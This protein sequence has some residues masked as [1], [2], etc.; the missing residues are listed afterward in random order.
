MPLEICPTWVMPSPLSTTNPRVPE[1]WAKLWQ[2]EPW[3]QG[4]VKTM[5]TISNPPKMSKS[6]KPGTIWNM[7][8]IYCWTACWN[9]FSIFLG[10]ATMWQISKLSIYHV[11]FDNIGTTLMEAHIGNIYLIC[12]NDMIIQKYFFL[13]SAC[14]S[15]YTQNLQTYPSVIKHGHGHHPCTE[16]VQSLNLVRGFPSHDWFPSH[17]CN[18][19]P[20]SDR[21][22]FD[23]CFNP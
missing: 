9:T 5:S 13:F 7:K 21:I 16:Y 14:Q 8:Y 23:L 17:V 6:G 20:M 2:G 22:F 19:H 12:C 11:V 3:S 15:V 4:H 10:V 18:F 1:I